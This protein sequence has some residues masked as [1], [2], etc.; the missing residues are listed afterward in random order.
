M[1][2]NQNLPKRNNA[3]LYAAIASFMMGAGIE[4]AILYFIFR[5]VFPQIMFARQHPAEV[6]WAMDR[7][8]LIQKAAGLLYFDEKNADAISV[9]RS[10]KIISVTK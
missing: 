6:K 8:V 10:D 3:A 2:Q 7:Y 5:P 9:V 4:L 1:R